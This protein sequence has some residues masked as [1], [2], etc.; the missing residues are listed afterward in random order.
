MGLPRIVGGN[1]FR[2]DGAGSVA[3]AKAVGLSFITPPYQRS[4]RVDDC[5]SLGAYN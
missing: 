1:G 2:V 4:Q 5:H 3:F